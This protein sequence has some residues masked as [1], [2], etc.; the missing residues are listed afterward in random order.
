MNQLRLASALANLIKFHLFDVVH[1]RRQIGDPE[2]TKHIEEYIVIARNLY[3]LLERKGN[4]N[5]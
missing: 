1:Y 5:D 4:K 3:D 2:I